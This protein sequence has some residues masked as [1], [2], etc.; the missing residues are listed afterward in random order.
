MS[1]IYFLERSLPYIPGTPPEGRAMRRVGESAL[2]DQF[3]QGTIE[4]LDES[5]PLSYSPANSSKRIARRGSG[6]QPSPRQ[7]DQLEA[8]PA[9]AAATANV[10]GKHSRTVNDAID[11]VGPGAAT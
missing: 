5:Q 7:G 10:A 4:A 9:G 3:M 8:S 11:P 6:A 1:A 2:I